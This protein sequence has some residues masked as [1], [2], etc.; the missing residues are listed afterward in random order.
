MGASSESHLARLLLIHPNDVLR[1]PLDGER[2]D[3]HLLPSS[4]VL[5]TVLLR[6]LLLLPL[7]PVL[8]P[9]F[10]TLLEFLLVPRHQEIW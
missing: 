2:V 1:T 6:S 3:G 7:V 5:A 4:L 10:S 8:L 9:L